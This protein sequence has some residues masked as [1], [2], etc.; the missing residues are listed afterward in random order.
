MRRLLLALF[1]ACSGLVLLSPGPAFACSCADEGPRKLADRADV[2]LT[3]TLVDIEEAADAAGDT[4]YLVDV[5]RLYKG[6]DVAGSVEVLSASSGAACGLEGM[7]LEEDYVLFLQRSNE[8]YRAD[9]CGG[10]APAAAELVERVER[11][12]GAGTKVSAP[13]AARFTAVEDAEP[14]SFTRLAAPGGAL[15]IAGLLGLVLVRALGRDR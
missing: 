8:V 2:V 15:V 10:T 5:D 12:L 3:G 13:P 14:T 11:A 6:P 9:L 1:L 4:T 7:T